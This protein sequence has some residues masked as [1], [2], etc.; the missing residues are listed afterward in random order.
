ME[1]SL[2]T[3]I[4][5][6]STGFVGVHLV[7]ELLVRGVKVSALCRENSPNIDRL[8]SGVDIIF[9]ANKLPCADVFYHLAWESASGQGRSDAV[10][11]SG[12]AEMTLIALLTAKKLDC[13]RFLALGTIYENL[14]GQVVA[15]AKSGGSDFYILSKNYAHL[16]ANQLA[17]KLG[18]DFV[19]C[20]ICHPI[21]RLIKAE[22]MM[23]FVVSNLI[24]GIKPDFGPALT[25]YDIVAVEDVAQGLY[26]LGSC[27]E[28]SEREYYIGSGCPRLLY[29][30][31]EDT[32]RILDASVPLGIGE[33]PDD[34]LRFDE[35]WFD[36]TLLQTETG[37]APKISFVDAVSNVA[38]SVV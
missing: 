18:I 1:R 30:W 19:W 3:A 24:R 16:M 35:E 37:Y 14:A 27:G 29:K 6:G 13:G 12:N 8:P 33:R 10:L 38:K 5:T 7:S 15:A 22:Q 17:Y 4:I 21:G 32:H 9:D 23:A 28:L 36:I 2:K 20:K 31:L 11:Q 34:G 25:P 26:L